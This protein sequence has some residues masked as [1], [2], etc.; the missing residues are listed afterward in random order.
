MKVKCEY[1]GNVFSK[2]N[3][4]AN[5]TKNFFC[6][7]ECYGKWKSEHFTQPSKKDMRFQNKIFEFAMRRLEYEQDD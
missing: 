3:P 6:S 7:R 5:P 2:R 1:C 4:S